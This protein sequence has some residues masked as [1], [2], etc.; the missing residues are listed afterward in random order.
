VKKTAA[1]MPVVL[2]FYRRSNRVVQ[3]WEKVWR[4]L[5]Q[6]SY[7]CPRPYYHFTKD[8][9]MAQ[10]NQLYKPRWKVEKVR[11]KCPI[12]GG[13]NAIE[14]S[15]PEVT[16]HVDC[17]KCRN[18]FTFLELFKRFYPFVQNYRAGTGP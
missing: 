16:D 4:K 5:R 9:A 1:F 14:N 6:Q 3:A 13:Q 18:R 2:T 10:E 8:Q 12:C 11:I 7:P 17:R 15:V